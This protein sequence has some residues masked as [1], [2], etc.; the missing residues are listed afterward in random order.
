MDKD[1]PP[2]LTR[3]SRESGIVY[4]LV[5]V[6]AVVA[7]FLA[8]PGRPSLL[9]L[10]IFVIVGLGS[11]NKGVWLPSA[12]TI[13]PSLMVVLAA[14]GALDGGEG[15]FLGVA[16]VGAA[17]GVQF[18]LV[19]QHRFGEL[20]VNSS[21]YLLSALSAAAVYSIASEAPTVARLVVTFA[22]F[23]IVNMV[24]VLIAA[25]ILYEEGAAGIWRDMYPALPGAA[26]YAVLGA[27]VGQLY[28]SVGWY[29]VVL[30]L[31]PVVLA[32][33]MFN[34][35]L[36]LEEAHAATIQVFLRAIRAKDEYTG[37]HTL[38]VCTYSLYIGEQLGFSLSRM[39]HLEHAAL[40]HDIGKLAVPKHL[41]NKPGRL[42]DE[43]FRR[44]Q[45][46]A[47]VCID[48]L[49][50]V[51]FLKPMTAAAAG[52]H[53]RYDGGGYGGDEADRPLEAFIVAVADAYDAMTSTRAYRRA[54]PMEVAFEEL[55]SK[56]GTQFHPECVEALIGAIAARG[57]RHGYGHE[58][59]VVAY[60]VPPPVR[61]L[62]SAGLG[63]RVAEVE[64]TDGRE[65]RERSS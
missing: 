36:E 42:T 52:H 46:H 11:E 29:A 51:D 6:G 17:N 64:R 5:A 4:G 7:G 31:T 27:L 24:L 38:R 45:E 47:H 55:R 41:L 1:L 16:I 62:G 25:V 54:L 2:P 18:R 50:L 14:I 43:E 65:L 9:A 35:R 26:A 19:R 8:D 30:M 34:S 56:S 39:R 57:E 13:S 63:D 10:A 15:F 48:I 59:D 33:A 23:T 44:V 58:A 37:R 61:G 21:Q 20:S 12:I 49:D 32:R 3:L 28:T 40:M 22:A 53:A 60:D